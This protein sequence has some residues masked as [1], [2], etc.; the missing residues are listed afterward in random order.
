MFF[1]KLL[2]IAFRTWSA[3]TCIYWIENYL[4]G[5]TDKVSRTMY[6]VASYV[7]KKKKNF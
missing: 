4:K 6:D 1:R 2:G 3:D 5:N 7:M